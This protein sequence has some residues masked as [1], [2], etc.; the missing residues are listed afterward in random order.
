MIHK[1]FS[2]IRSE[3]ATRFYGSMDLMQPLLFF[4]FGL[5]FSV[6]RETDKNDPYFNTHFFR[7]SKYR[8]LSLDLASEYHEIVYYYKALSYMYL[9]NYAVSQN[10]AFTFLSQKFYLEPNRYV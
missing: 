7:K 8:K 10:W 1:H 6:F 2:S 3:E 9:F 5:F 4:G